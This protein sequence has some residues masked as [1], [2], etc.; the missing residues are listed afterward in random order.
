MRVRKCKVATI[1]AE[2]QPNRKPQATTARQP[3]ALAHCHHLA[4]RQSS[5]IVGLTKCVSK[6][7]VMASPNC[8]SAPAKA[9]GTLPVSQTLALHSSLIHFTNRRAPRRFRVIETTIAT[10]HGRPAESAKH[11]NGEWRYEPLSPYRRGRLK[12]STCLFR[13]NAQ[14]RRRSCNL[15]K[16]GRDFRKRV[17]IGIC[18]RWACS[19]KIFV[20]CRV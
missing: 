16:I 19:C 9:V 2:P 1:A 18:L 20:A 5:V 6:I 8:H 3:R 10:G 14:L 13:E 17:S 15:G 7:C 12:R 11:G 4:D